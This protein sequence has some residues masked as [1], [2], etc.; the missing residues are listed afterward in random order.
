MADIV[1]VNG[2]QNIIVDTIEVFFTALPSG[3]GGSGARVTAFNAS[4]NG[5]ASAF[6]MAYIFD[7]TGTVLPA[8]IPRKIV[9]KDR[10]DL[11]PSI[12]SHIIPP[13]GTLRMETSSLNTIT[14]RVTGKEF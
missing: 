9:V 14:F 13:G 8:V 3:N 12:V 7:A 2:K 5:T 10:F 6:Y 1:M 11:G 4:N